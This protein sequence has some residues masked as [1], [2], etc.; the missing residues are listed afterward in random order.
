[1]GPEQSPGGATEGIADEPLQHAL[2]TAYSFLNKRERTAAEVD[3]RLRHERFSSETIARTLALLHDEGTLDDHRFARLFTDDKRTLE[4]WGSE[5]IRR[6]LVQRGIDPDTVAAAVDA[7]R[8]EGESSS[9]GERERALAVLQ[10]RFP[11]RPRN[12]RDRDRALA[13]LLRKG[14][15]PELAVEALS[16]YS[17]A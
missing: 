16:A 11:E 8:G 17:R 3:R 4:G 1:V 14:Y 12:R 6:V 5:R 2:R 10:R 9:E 7:S 13:V 15:E